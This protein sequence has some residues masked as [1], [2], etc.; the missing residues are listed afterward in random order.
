[1][2]LNELNKLLIESKDNVKIISMYLDKGGCGKSSHAFNFASYC[3]DILNKRVLVIDGDRS[4]NLTTTFG[5]DGN[6][7]IADIF[8]TGEFE[9]YHSTNQNIDII[10]GS[11]EF[12]DEKTDIQSASTKYLVFLEWIDA[13]EK[14]LNE[15]YDFIIIDTHNDDSRV[16][17]NLITSAHLI[18]N[19][20]TPDGDS[21]KAINDLQTLIDEELIPRTKLPR[22]KESVFDAEVAI[23]PNRIPFFGLNISDEAKAFLKQ[24]SIFKNVL[25]IIPDRPLISKSRLHNKSIFELYE[26]MSP[27]EKAKK[28]ELIEH[29][30]SVYADIAALA[31]KKVKQNM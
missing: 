25:G 27:K 18:V 1:M 4:K 11:K 12:T 2:E 10:C 17:L 3:A 8:K 5:I 13:N 9:I 21:Y 20:A 31:C 19:T 14:F 23:L 7:T 6:L 22:S 16:T 30:K 28:T 26:E 24:L 15:N 29:I